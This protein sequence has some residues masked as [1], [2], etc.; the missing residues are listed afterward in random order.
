VSPTEG[1]VAGM[2]KVGAKCSI[3]R[4]TDGG[5]TFTNVFKS[6]T[7]STLCWKLHFPSD[8]VGYVAV[9]DT[10]GGPDTFGKTTDGGLTW[11][12]LPLPPT[13]KPKSAYSAIGVGFITE[14]IGW[15]SAEDTDLPVFR[16][17]D[18][19]AT[20][21]E[22]PVLKS[23]INRFRFVDKNTAYA[24]GANGWKLEVAWNGK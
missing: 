22:E 4:T 11:Q 2:S 23:P 8:K 1:I 14:N 6:T 3:E 13:A 12:E 16:T 9:Q 18:G 7:P 21:E 19:G 10:T 15:M 24:I 17:V 5:A 20:W